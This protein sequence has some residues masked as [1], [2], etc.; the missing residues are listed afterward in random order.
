[1]RSFMECGETHEGNFQARVPPGLLYKHMLID[2][3]NLVVC[4][5]YE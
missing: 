3:E 2:G 4:W 5:I 1:V